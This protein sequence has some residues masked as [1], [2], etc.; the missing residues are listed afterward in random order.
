MDKQNF[1]D[2]HE[3][4]ELINKI[5]R[6][7]ERLFQSREK[8]RKFATNK[9]N[10]IGKPKRENANANLINLFVKYLLIYTVKIKEE[11]TL[12]EDD[13]QISIKFDVGLKRE[14]NRIAM[15]R[16]KLHKAILVNLKYKENNEI[17]DLRNE[18]NE[19]IDK[20]EDFIETWNENN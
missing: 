5:G 8:G 3:I 1:L 17:T 12:K 7:L 14:N 9:Y 2:F 19:L 15:E 10:V 20:I 4:K 11:S 13:L 18:N 6:E 16:E